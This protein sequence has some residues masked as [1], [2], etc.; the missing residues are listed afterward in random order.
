M[1]LSAFH[2]MGLC[3]A[4]SI[5]PP[6]A[7]W[8][9]TA[10]WQVGVVVSP[11]SI[12][13]AP[14]LSSAALAT[15]WNSGPETRLSRPSTMARDGA[16]PLPRG[17]AIDHAPNAAAK[18]AT[19]SGESASPTRPRTPD[20]LTINPSYAMP[21]VL[22]MLDVMAWRAVS[23]PDRPSK[24]SEPGRARQAS[25]RSPAC[26]IHEIGHARHD[27]GRAAGWT[28]RPHVAS[29]P[30]TRAT[31]AGGTRRPQPRSSDERRARVRRAPAT[32]AR[33]ARWSRS[34]G[35]A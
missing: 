1:N 9:S 21:A 16:A 15:R 20:T 27:P 25:R 3:D 14:T 28:R 33:H 5:S 11:T 10:S 24:V 4:D 6:A 8:C 12:T 35:P 2:S 19:T 29:L 30:H 22:E 7:W 31:H 17:R 18:R 26:C 13:W 32:A 23:R 34:G